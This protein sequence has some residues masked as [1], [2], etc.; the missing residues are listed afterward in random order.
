VALAV[1]VFVIDEGHC[2]HCRRVIRGVGCSLQ[3]LNKA[4]LEVEKK[5]KT[6]QGRSF[7]RQV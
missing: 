4:K 5:K 2:T 6:A 7:K 1:I 3:A